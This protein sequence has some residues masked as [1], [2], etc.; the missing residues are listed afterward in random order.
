MKRKEKDE[1]G[2]IA[3]DAVAFV[4][5]ADTRRDNRDNMMIIKDNYLY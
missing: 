2:D 4:T 3:A 1:A 5:L